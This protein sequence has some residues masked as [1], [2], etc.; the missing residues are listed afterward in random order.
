MLPNQTKA[1]VLF[2]TKGYLE[3]CTIDLP[4]LQR[5]QILVKVLYSGVCRSQLMEINGQ[6][7]KDAWLPHL[8]GHEGCGEVIAIGQDVTKVEIGDVVILG[9][10]KGEGIDAAPAVYEYE[11]QKINSG[12]VT[13][14]SNHTIISENR[15]VKLPKG[16]PMDVGVLFGCALLTGAGIVFNELQP[17][18]NDT[19]AVIGLG[20]IGLSALM[21]LTH[22]KVKNIIAIDK[23]NSR[24][25]LA[26]KFG[27]SHA[28]NSHNVDVT[29]WVLQNFPGGLDYCVEAAGQVATIELGFSLIKKEG[30][31]LIFASHPPENQMISLRPHD[32]ISGKKIQGSWGGGCC[33]DEDIPKLSDAYLIDRMPLNELLNS[34]YTLDQIND[35]V[36]DLETGKA[37]RPL[38]VMEHN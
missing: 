29:E 5:G 1:A 6:R 26:T 38:I 23:D 3:V 12:R 8:L 22:Q 30:G 20:G 11:G 18:Q 37:F 34:R 25:E 13:T 31:L 14:F 36:A 19:V 2:E 27:A 15:T 17:K 33:P 32:L 16:V 9:W 21:A 4:K 24:L 35:A 10:I 28:I 7:G